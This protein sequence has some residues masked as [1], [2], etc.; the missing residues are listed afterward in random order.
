MNEVVMVT[1]KGSKPSAIPD[2]EGGLDELTN[3]G[4]EFLVRLSLLLGGFG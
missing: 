3:T 4:I 2:R 1:L